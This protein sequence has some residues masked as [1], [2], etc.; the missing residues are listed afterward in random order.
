MPKRLPIGGEDAHV[1][2]AIPIFVESRPTSVLY[3]EF[4]DGAYAGEQSG[5]RDRGLI[6]W[7]Y[8][9]PPIKEIS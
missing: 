6:L 8:S 3:S 2:T 7:K 5:T 9:I 1:R 4:V